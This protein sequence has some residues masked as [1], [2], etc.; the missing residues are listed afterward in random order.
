MKSPFRHSASFF[1]RTGTAALFSAAFVHLIS[2][3]PLSPSVSAEEQ[4]KPLRVVALG[5]SIARGYGC[6]PEE[7]YGRLLADHLAEEL[8]GTGTTVTFANYGVDGL[9]SEGLRTMLKTDEIQTAVADADLVTVSI[10]GNDLLGFLRQSLGGALALDPDS[11][12]PWQ[13]F[14][15]KLRAESRRETFSSLL[16]LAGSGDFYRG[17][18]AASADMLNNVRAVLDFLSSSSPGAVLLLTTI[19]PPTAEPP[20]SLLVDAFLFRFN[21]RLKNGLSD[22]AV[23]LADCNQAF[24]DYAGEEALTFTVTGWSEPASWNPDPHPTPAG[25]RLM[26]ETHFPLVQDLINT[27]KAA[28]PVMESGEKTVPATSTAVSAAET[29]PTMIAVTTDGMPSPDSPGDA[30]PGAVGATRFFPLLLIALPIL[31]L[32][33]LLFRRSAARR[34]SR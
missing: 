32:V 23:R 8:D 16:K 24:H 1:R 33:W 19:P 4:V 7:A 27:R 29:S 6:R 26:A 31:F 21:A 11:S 17:L 10:G 5:D 18:D 13:D 2:F 9:T 22:T 20:F 28:A 25:H 3:I 12:A 30:T 15:G 34:R 14:L